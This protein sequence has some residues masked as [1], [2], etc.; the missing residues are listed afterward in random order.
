MNDTSNSARSADASVTRLAIQG[1]SCGKCAA[2]VTSALRAVP[3][4]Q[5]AEVDLASASARVE[6]AVDAARLIEAVHEAG[7]KA[8]EA[9]PDVAVAAA[10]PGP[11]RRAP[12]T[13]RSRA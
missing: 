13:C 1:M 10:E 6:G 2:R 5:V 8:M 3:G 7:Y 12:S 11:A 4:V 9:E